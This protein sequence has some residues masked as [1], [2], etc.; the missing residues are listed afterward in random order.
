MMPALPATPIRLDTAR[1]VA[2]RYRLNKRL[3]VARRMT[4]REN[5]RH[6]LRSYEEETVA[7]DEITLRDS[8]D[9][10]LAG[11]SVLHLA[12][13]D[14]PEIL[15]EIGIAQDQ[16]LGLLDHRDVA[17]YFESTYPFAPPVL[18]R[19]AAVDPGG[20]DY[21]AALSEE[22]FTEG[23]S[24]AFQQFLM[25]DAAF[26]APGPLE[27]FLS[28]L[29]G[30]TIKGYD[31][32]D[33]K[34]AFRREHKMARLLEKKAGRRMLEGLQDFLDFSGE[35]DR[36]LSQWTRFPL[37]AGLVWLHYGY[38]YGAGGK[39]MRQVAK[40]LRDTLDQVAAREAG[41]DEG[42]LKR[43]L[44]PT[45]VVNR[46]TD[47]NGY[48]R[49]LLTSCAGPLRQWRKAVDRQRKSKNWRDSEF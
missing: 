45:A 3:R 37:F 23:W 47:L 27:D 29:D 2:H 34:G 30:Y 8:L 13:L 42:M 40:W 26:N 10:L 20:A 44:P 48:P 35:L 38:W 17:R 11:L 43:P 49:A 28:L 22:R 33:L 46:L 39:R 24:E 6:L 15:D 14:R 19:E 32:D 1:Q 4:Y 18:L 12:G 7:G 5:L 25:L 21:V 41:M 36:L 9:E 31:L 16:V